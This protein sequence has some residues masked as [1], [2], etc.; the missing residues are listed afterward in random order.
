MVVVGRGSWISNG[1]AGLHATTAWNRVLRL[2][3]GKVVAGQQGKVVDSTNYH[4]TD[5]EEVEL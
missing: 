1:R 3:K 2:T 5:L 4:G